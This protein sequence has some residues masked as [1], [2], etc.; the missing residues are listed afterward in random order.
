[1]SNMKNAELE[2]R[3][4]MEELIADDRF[5]ENVLGYDLWTALKS[6]KA[7]R[8]LEAESLLPCIACGEETKQREET[9]IGMIFL[10]RIE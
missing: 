9:A 4:V 6:V 2:C 8:K 7:C 5:D 1:M 10:M 3:E